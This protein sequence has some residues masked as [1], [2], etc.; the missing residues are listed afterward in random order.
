MIARLVNGVV[1]VVGA[2]AGAQFPAFY[3]QY[4][5]RLGGRLDQ[6]RIEAGRI[7]GAAQAA[8]LRL[9][10]YIERFLANPDPAVRATGLMHQATLADQQA[11]REAQNA[12][13]AATGGERPI[14][15]L[16]HLDSDLA[17]ATLG[18]FQPALPLT[19]E[20]AVY[21]LGGLALAVF[22]AALI[23]P[24][25]SRRPAAKPA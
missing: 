7:A 16:R 3:Q 22:L 20:S 21:A 18:D 24:S 1:A 12:L 8:G 17:W 6:A 2:A 13:A 15:F 10:D 25:L 11:L 19:L 4:L 14:A 5:Q 9:A 23:G